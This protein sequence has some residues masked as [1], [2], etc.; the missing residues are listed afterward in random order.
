MERDLRESPLYGEVEEHFRKIYGPGLGGSGAST[1]PSRTGAGWPSQARSGEARRWARAG[2]P[3]G[4]GARAPRRP[5]EAQWQVSS[6]SEHEAGAR[7]SQDARTLLISDRREKGRMQRMP[8][9]RRPLTGGGGAPGA[10][11]HDEENMVA[12]RRA[13]P[14]NRR[15]PPRGRAGRRF[16]AL[17]SE[18]EMPDWTQRWTLEDRQV[19]TGAR[20]GRRR[21]GDVER[22]HGRSERLGAAWAATV[23]RGR[24]GLGGSG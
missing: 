16:G 19:W 3:G 23:H 9:P 12:R 13:D 21:V 1:P 2:R 18:R 6:G 10:S 14:R 5:N 4:G 15:G 22:S 11:G 20:G 24:G 8:C 17:E 7:W